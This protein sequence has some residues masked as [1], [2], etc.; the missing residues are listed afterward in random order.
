MPSQTRGHFA[1]LGYCMDIGLPSASF[2]K[3]KIKHA[4]S[5][6]VC[7]VTVSHSYLF[8]YQSRNSSTLSTSSLYNSRC[9]KKP[10][11]KPHLQRDLPD[12]LHIQL[13]LI[14][15]SIGSVPEKK[16][17]T[18]KIYCGFHVSQIKSLQQKYFS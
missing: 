1:L 11:L 8:A 14:G 9:R 13:N 5:P 18:Q 10:N 12:T 3:I 7:I 6:L 2:F 4:W 17:V 16:N 15:H